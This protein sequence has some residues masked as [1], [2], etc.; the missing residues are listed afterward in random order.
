MNRKDRRKSGSGIVKGHTADGKNYVR[1]HDSETKHF[2]SDGRSRKH[3]I[4]Q[5]KK[6][7]LEC[8][9]LRKDVSR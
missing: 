3:A 5:A 6:D 2:Y 1:W 4:L 9:N 7:R 8:I